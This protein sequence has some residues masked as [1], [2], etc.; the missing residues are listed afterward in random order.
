[1]AEDSLVSVRGPCKVLLK[2]FGPNPGL[3]AVCLL[4]FQQTPFIQAINSKV[5]SVMVPEVVR[6]VVHGV[7]E[8]E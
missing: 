4:L 8:E 5:P 3:F 6:K 2:S 1:M 7:A